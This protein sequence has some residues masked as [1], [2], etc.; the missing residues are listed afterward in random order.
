MVLEKEMKMGKV[1][2]ANKQW[3]NFD[4][5]SSPGGLRKIKNVL[6]IYVYR[7]IWIARLAVHILDY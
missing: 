4:Q 3:T 2:Y 1:Y 6:D 5:E 7:H